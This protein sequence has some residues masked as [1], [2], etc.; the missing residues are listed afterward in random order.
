MGVEQGSVSFSKQGQVRLPAAASNLVGECRSRTL[1]YAG[2]LSG[3]L[4]ETLE[5][6]ISDRSASVFTPP[7]DSRLVAGLRTI[8]K[9]KVKL[10]E[11]FAVRV[12]YHFDRHLQLG[13]PA[14]NAADSEE[15]GTGLSLVDDSELEESLAVTTMTGKL[16]ERYSEELF[17]LG[18]RLGVLLSGEPVDN[19]R[20][21]M[22]PDSF[23]HA[24]RDALAPLALEPGVRVQGY[25]LFERVL[26]QALGDLYTGL[27]QFLIEQGVLPQLKVKIRTQPSAPHHAGAVAGRSPAAPSAGAGG[28][29]SGAARASALDDGFLGEMV[30][31]VQDQMYQAI[32]YLLGT[33]GAPPADVPPGGGGTGAGGIY[34]PATPMLIDTLSSLQH[35]P[36]LVEYSGE[37][38]RGGL[39]QHVVGRFETMD[40]LGRPGVINQIDDETI[41]VISM[42]FDYILDD[43]TLPDFIKALIGRLQIPVLKVAIVDRGFFTDKLHP[44]RLLLNEL[45]YAGVGWT[46]ESEAAKDRLYEKMGATVRRI[47]DEFDN[48]VEIFANLLDD[49]R[50][51]LDEEKRNFALAREQIGIQVQE[52]GQ[53]ERIKLRIAEEIAARLVDRAVPEEVREFLATSWRQLLTAVHQEEG[54]DSPARVRAL[55]V[56]EDLIWSVEPKTTAE[57]RRRLG[58]LLPILLEELREGQLRIGRGEDEIR[59]FAAVL[60]RHHFTSLKAGRTRTEGR[61][62]PAQE[63]P[64][65]A[66]AQ[67]LRREDTPDKT[68]LNEIDRMFRELS[69]DIDRLPEVDMQGLSGFDDLIDRKDP[70]RQCSFEK[71]MA[72]MGFEADSDAGPR[73]EDRHTGL[74]RSLELGTWVELTESDGRKL[75]VKLAWVGDA[76]TNYSFVNRQYK[77]VAERPMYVL[78]EEFRSGAAR[79]IEDVALFDRALDGVISGIM[80]FAR[81]R[82]QADHA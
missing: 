29:R 66:P 70:E 37:L 42:I 68:K 33:H 35:D 80:K 7:E 57:Q 81:P 5:K 18:Q 49:F 40:N 9:N 4:C 3:L 48:D 15:P 22:G 14:G 53:L 46:E 8:L 63:A 52:N 67:P 77:V 71:M 21:P 76:Y 38:L 59:S 16:Q 51:F 43:K 24:I 39:K 11:E 78:A 44:A 6:D 55:Q 25:K 41:D 19:N 56:M 60:E 26:L 73:I 64:A 32:Q 36:A 79:V 65:T 34:L 50:A 30:T 12:Q 28:G 13:A 31:P 54:E 72:E 17:G 10:G 62:A 27:N 58:V 20:L 75:R 45:A 74:V 69:G 61:P 2:R 23:C 1:E 82:T 47:L